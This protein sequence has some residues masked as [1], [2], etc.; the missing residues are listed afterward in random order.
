MADLSAPG[1]DSQA[2]AAARQPLPS[3]KSGRTDPAA[4]DRSAKEFESVF[5]SQMMSQMWSGV[6]VDETFGGGHAEEVWRGMMVEE[7]GKMI[8]RN[9]GVGIAD[10]MKSQLLALQEVQ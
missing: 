1:F 2:L 10:Q 6:E 8:A 4:L 7:Y 3:F 5:L 9:G